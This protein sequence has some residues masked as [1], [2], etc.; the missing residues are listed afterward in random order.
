MPEGVTSA[1]LRATAQWLVPLCLEKG[2][3]FTDRLH[4]HLYGDTRGT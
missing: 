2:F 1:A 4:I 3:N